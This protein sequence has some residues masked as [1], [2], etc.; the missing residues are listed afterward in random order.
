MSISSIYDH[1]ELASKDIP[2]DQNMKIIM[3]HSIRHPIDSVENQSEVE[4]TNEGKALAMHFG[5]S[6]NRTIGFLGS[7]D[8]RRCIQTLDCISKGANAQSEI[9]IMNHQLRDPHALDG[10]VCEESFKKLPVESIFYRLKNGI[11]LPGF[12]TLIESVKIMLDGIFSYG[13]RE[14]T[15]DLFCTHD[16]QIALLASDL[17]DFGEP[18]D[19]RTGSEWPMM[20]EG[21]IFTGNRNCFKAYWRNN[22]KIMENYLWAPL[23]IVFKRRNLPSSVSLQ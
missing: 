19:D 7:S 15:L 12:R 11:R 9:N 8:A 23:K 21:I 2:I 6:I 3:R 10:R 22:T 20:L 18:I 1:M 5:R 16:F 17:F 13:N 14:N 4:L